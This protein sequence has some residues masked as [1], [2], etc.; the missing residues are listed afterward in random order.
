M[1]PAIAVLKPNRS[2]SDVTFLTAANAAAERELV[3]GRPSSASRNAP[4]AQRFRP[5]HRPPRSPLVG[6]EQNHDAVQKALRPTDALVGPL[7]VVLGRSR[8]QDRDPGDVRAVLADE[9]SHRHAVAG[10]LTHRDRA[11]HRR[12]ASV[13]LDEGVAPLRE[14]TPHRLAILAVLRQTQRLDQLEG[15]GGRPRVRA[16]VTRRWTIPWVKSGTARPR[17]RVRRRRGP[18]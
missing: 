4:S 12:E 1:R 2:V 9:G 14:G 16:V 15:R 5:A 17:A 7:H 6:T 11:A 3:A 8:E 10:A 13:A 18:S